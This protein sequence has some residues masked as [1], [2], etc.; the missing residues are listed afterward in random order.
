MGRPFYRDGNG[1]IFA[2]RE[3][4]LCNFKQALAYG[5]V[6]GPAPALAPGAAFGFPSW[7][8]SGSVTAMNCPPLLPSRSGWTIVLIFIPGVRVLGTQPC[9]AKPA[10]PP[11][12]IAHCSGWPWALLT[13]IRIQLCGL[14]H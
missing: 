9:R 7:V 10:G 1:A 12:S 2:R 11:I 6:A 13:I 3:Q 4:P 8:P 14:V 5:F